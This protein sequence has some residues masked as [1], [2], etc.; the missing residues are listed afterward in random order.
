M[1]HQL[2]IDGK[3]IAAILYALTRMDGQ[4]DPDGSRPHREDWRKEAHLIVEL[5]LMSPVV[6]PPDPWRDDR[7]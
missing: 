2:I 6:Q 1:Y 3:H 4:M 5:S 7:P